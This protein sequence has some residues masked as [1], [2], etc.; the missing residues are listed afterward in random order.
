MRLIQAGVGGF[1]GSWLWAV[2]Q[3]DNFE[4]VALVDPNPDALRDAGE[5]VGVP[6]EQ[7]FGSLEAAL[8]S[9]EADG[10]INVTPAALHESTTLEA[11]SAGLHVL[12]E[13]PISDTMESA[14]RMVR[15]ADQRG[16]TLMVTQQFRYQEQPRQL[17][18]MIAEGWIGDIDHV[19]VEFQLQGLL[20]GWRK[21]MPHPF[22]MDMAIHHFDLMR[23]LLGSNAER[24]TARTWNPSVSNTKGDN[25]AFAWIDFENGV[26]VNYSGSFASP[27]Q[28]TGWNGRWVITGTRG[29]LVWNPRDE[30]GPIRIMR[31]NAD[32]SQYQGQH[33]FTPLAEP[34]GEAIWPE[35]MGATGHHYDLYHWRAC[36]EHGLEPETSGRDNL[37]TLAL[38]LAAI[39]SA[40]SG[41]T[42]DVAEA[43]DLPGIRV[44]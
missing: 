42:V 14:R 5:Q 20:A 7:Q 41:R 6:P 12:V 31:Q 2:K 1:G 43:F 25:G 19:V 38:T 26:K 27:G 40:D 28:D 29:S 22:L 18:K 15:A 23:Y 30:W 39:E 10:L 13:K 33:F 34:W 4:H 9:V 35:P 16:R 32:L 24:V 21:E 36:I 17:R 3:C 37:N 8:A 44:A 11:I